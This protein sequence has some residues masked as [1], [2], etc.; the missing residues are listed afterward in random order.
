MFSILLTKQ[1]SE[2]NGSFNPNA[3]SL[4]GLTKDFC[5]VFNLI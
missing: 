2:F 3:V 5:L 4:N 1:A